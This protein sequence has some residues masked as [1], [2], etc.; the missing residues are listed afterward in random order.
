M[1]LLMVIS[2]FLKDTSVC[3]EMKRKM[4]GNFLASKD[5]MKTFKGKAQSVLSRS[6]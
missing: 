6:L 1:L 3:D 5:V 4:I 2:L